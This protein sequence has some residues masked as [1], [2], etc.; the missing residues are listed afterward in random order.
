VLGELQQ[1]GSLLQEA[2]LVVVGV[3]SGL[4]DGDNA[5]VTL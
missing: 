2:F 1:G 3:V 5:A 4:P